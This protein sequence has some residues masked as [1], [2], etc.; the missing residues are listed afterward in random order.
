MA[1]KDSGKAKARAYKGP[2]VPEFRDP[3]ELAK[4][5][6]PYLHVYRDG[7]VCE[8][9]TRGHA[10]PGGR[11]PLEIVVDASEG[12]IPLWDEDVILRWRFQEQSMQVFVNP[13]GAK[14]YIRAL[15]GEALLLWGA[16]V[17]I[18]FTEADDVWDFEFAV[19]PQEK[20]TLN[21]CTLARAFF[22]DAGR[23]D[24]VMYPTMFQQPLNEQI[25]TMAHEL[26]HVF[27]LRHFFADVEETRWRSVIF[28]EHVPFS[29]MNYGAESVMTQNDRD[30]L[31]TLYE[32]ARTGVLTEVNGTP[33]RLV[34]PFSELR[35]PLLS[36]ELVALR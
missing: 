28:G 10:T 14:A 9:D 2:E 23:H 31:R 6:E 21:G 20:C 12:F 16:G 3:K 19:E 5:Q 26:G 17:P 32:L 24:L 33:I 4:A 30:D 34:R 27:G 1:K 29:I 35:E 7:H 13:E 25:E 22:P 11:S 36:P 8:T 15:F 18:R